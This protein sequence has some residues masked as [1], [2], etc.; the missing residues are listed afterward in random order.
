MM[1][2]RLARPPQLIDINQVA[3]LKELKVDGDDLVIGALVRHAELGRLNVQGLTHELSALLRRVMSQIAHYPIRTRGTFCGSVAHADPASEW[4][5]VAATFDARMIAHSQNG[6]REITAAD[7]FLGAM[8]TALHSTEILT[9]ARLPL[10]PAGTRFAFHEFAQRAGDFALGM[11]LVVLELVD[12]RMRRVRVGIG[13][14]EDHPRR[15][16]EAE[17]LLEG[18]EP[19][20]AIFGRAAEAVRMAVVPM[21]DAKT[22]AHYRRDLAAHLTRRALVEA[23]S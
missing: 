22:D 5:L 20:A 7:Y 6:A 16:A 3:A 13:G 19:G 1:A 11:A 17:V 2:F 14:V 18:A 15:I 8:S 23:T 4:C 10:L 9:A 12:G 21:I